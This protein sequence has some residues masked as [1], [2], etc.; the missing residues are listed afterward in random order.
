MKSDELDVINAGLITKALY[1]N[2]GIEGNLNIDDDHNTL[3]DLADVRGR[4]TQM[5]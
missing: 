5:L 2:E 1:V 3:L 4:D